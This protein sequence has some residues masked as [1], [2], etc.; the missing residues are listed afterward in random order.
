MKNEKPVYLLA[1]GNWR[2]PGAI[3]P[4]LKEVI[5]ASGQKKDIRVA[6]VGTANGDDYSFFEFAKNYIVKAGASKVE[7]IIL[8]KKNAD[9]EKAKRLLDQV[10][11]VFVSGGD[12]E[13]GMRW[14]KHHGLIPFLQELHS[15]GVLFFGLSAGSIMLG[16]KWV[17]WSDPKDESTAELFNCI[18]I[19]PVLCDTHA[20]QDNWEEL[21][22]AVRLLGNKATGYGIPTGG[23]LIVSG[24]N[25]IS[26][27]EKPAVF[28]VNNSGRINK[29]QDIPAFTM[30]DF[31]FS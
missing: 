12:V 31:K 28:L 3:L 11:A 5:K 19:A 1:G 27:V 24:K 30:D 17:R 4:L 21:A 15:R 6:Y 14:L 29:T 8:A 22:T 2:S 7:R 10:D 23:M 9:T 26:A 13:E 18:G 25:N 16:T 20:E